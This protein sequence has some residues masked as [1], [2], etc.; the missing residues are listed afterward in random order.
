ML[1]T[2]ADTSCLLINTVKLPDYTSTR[3]AFGLESQR[4]F[5]HLPLMA[6]FMNLLYL[7]SEILQL[8]SCYHTV[9]ILCYS[10]RHSVVY[11]VTSCYIF[12]LD[13]RLI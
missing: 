9:I 11:T 3:C 7:D 1:R 4:F 12:V 5:D 2:P 8:S 6:Y 10:L 13:Y